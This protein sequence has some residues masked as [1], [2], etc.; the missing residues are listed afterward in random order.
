MRSL[1][2]RLFLASLVGISL[3]CSVA[4]AQSGS[5][6]TKL[7][8][9]LLPGD[10]RDGQRIFVNLNPA[11]GSGTLS[12]V[13]R[14]ERCNIRNAPM[15]MAMLG[16]RI[17]LKSA[18]GYATLCVTNMSLEL[19]PNPGRGGEIGYRAELTVAGTA[20]SKGPILRGRVTEP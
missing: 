11:S 4:F 9:V 15:T 16:G 20:A 7:T 17:T 18:P 19:V 1:P 13:F 2:N 14:E 12:L 8:G 3:T 6:P 5:L 10:S